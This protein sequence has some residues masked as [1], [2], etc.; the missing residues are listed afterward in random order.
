MCTVSFIP[1]GK[2]AFVLTSNRDEAP[3]RQTDYPAIYDINETKMVFPKDAIAG[4]TWIGLSEKQRLIC[5]L[6]G[7]FT[8]CTN[9][10]E[11]INT[12][13]LD[14]IE[15]FTIVIVD[16]KDTLKVYE[17]VWDEDEKHFSE[18]PNEPRLW[19]SSTLYTSKMKAERQNWFKAYLTEEDYS[20]NS[21]LNFHRTAGK[22]N[23]DYGTIMDRTF[24]KT[25][26]ITQVEKL[27]DTVEMRY[28]DLQKDTL[29]IIDLP[30]TE[31]VNE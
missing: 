27:P 13:N 30:I 25:T 16:W 24:V 19:S 4:G 21:I 15:P 29:S 17:L 26:S 14:D 11:T 9:I 1:K 28:K 10:I 20:A 8:P 18:L 7:G 5:L 2:K 23:K 6:N 12:Y 22:G 31:V 3:N